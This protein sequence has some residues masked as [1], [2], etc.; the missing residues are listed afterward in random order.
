MLLFVVVCSGRFNDMGPGIVTGL[1]VFSILKRNVLQSCLMVLVP[2]CQCAAGEW[3]Y[4]RTS[5]SAANNKVQL[6]C[7]SYLVLRW[8]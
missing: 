2:T 5:S 4:T 7:N 8:W 3:W 1:Q 6:L